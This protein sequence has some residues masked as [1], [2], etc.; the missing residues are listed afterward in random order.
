MIKFDEDEKPMVGIRT[1]A[2]CAHYVRCIP[3]CNP[4]D[5]EKDDLQW[6]GPDFIITRRVGTED[7][8]ALIMASLMRTSKH[9]DRDEFKK[10][11]IKKKKEAAN[12]RKDKIKK[13]LDVGIE[14]EK[15]SDDAEEEKEEEGEGDKKEEEKKE[16]DETVD[17]RVFI[18]IGRSNTQQR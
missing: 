10:W 9:E 6:C 2:E 7:D 14:K 18:A 12:E 1:F 4:G 5:F 17:D 13:L 15:D 11:A 16:D 8:H 3:Y